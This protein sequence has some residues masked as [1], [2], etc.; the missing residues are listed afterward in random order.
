MN[1]SSK[2]VLLLLISF[3]GILVVAPLLN[4]VH[5]LVLDMP[6]IMFWLFLW[7]FITPILTYA[8]YRIDENKKSEGVAQ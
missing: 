8:I 5:I 4:G 3:V 7:F 6:L 2:K 1:A